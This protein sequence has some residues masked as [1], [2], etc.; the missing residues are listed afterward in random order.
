MSLAY[1]KGLKTRYKN[2]L[3]VELGKSE[4]LLTREVSDF[5]LE[6]QI[7]KVN[8]S[9][10]RFDEFGPKF[11]ETLE[12]LSLTLE[13]A[14]AEEDLKT[15]QKESEL[16]FNI[17]TEVTSRKEELKLI[18]NF[19]QEKYKNLSK[20][21]PD[22]KIEQLIEIQMQMMQ[23]MQLQNAKPQHDEQNHSCKITKTGNNGKGLINGQ[24]KNY[25]DLLKSYI[26]ARGSRRKSVQG[27]TNDVKPQQ[28]K[29]KRSSL[30][31]NR[32][33]VNHKCDIV[34]MQ[35][36]KTAITN[37]SDTCNEEIRLLLDL[38][39]ST[40]I[41]F[42]TLA[43][44]LKLKVEET[45]CAVIAID[46]SMPIKPP[47]EDFW[48]LE[49]I[50][51][52][53]PPENSNDTKALENLTILLSTLMNALIMLYSLKSSNVVQQ[54]WEKVLNDS[55][56]Q[57]YVSNKGISWKF[58]VE[59]A[60]WMGGFYERLVGLE[61]EAVVNSRPLAYIGEDIDSNI[62]LTLS[63][64]LTLNKHTGIPEGIDNDDASRI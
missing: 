44:K 49:T 42:E 39:K 62:V 55:D 16:Y 12:R 10:R 63:C 27:E 38:G 59:L 29:C 18:D 8:K 47:L 32:H 25:A 58:I 1:L 17:I 35:T 7:R 30:D 33:M 36:A 21:E 2:L 45:S 48:N 19:L 9:Y 57:N 23:Q 53:E 52:S 54:E 28:P 13:T 64:F 11:E 51:I 50:G 46:K 14:K 60:P 6:S 34:L 31:I 37:L 26:A 41:C 4:E 20:P 56:I 43:R 61:V 40:H 5:D 22:S 3:E 24:S 15:F